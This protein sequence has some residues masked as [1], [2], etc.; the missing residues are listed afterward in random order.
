MVCQAAF[1]ALDY[2]VV[3]FNVTLAY[4]AQS[5]YVNIFFAAGVCSSLV[6]ELD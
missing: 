1:R 6:G 3:G 4:A 5:L 2:L